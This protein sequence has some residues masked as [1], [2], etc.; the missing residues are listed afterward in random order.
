MWSSAVKLLSLQQRDMSIKI[1]G[2][3]TEIRNHSLLI[4]MSLVKEKVFFHIRNHIFLNLLASVMHKDSV[5][6]YQHRSY[7]DMKKTHF[8]VDFNDLGSWSDSS[9]TTIALS[10]V[11]DRYAGQGLGWLWPDHQDL[12]LCYSKQLT[13]SWHSTL[14]FSCL[15]GWETL[16]SSL[17]FLM[18]LLF[19]WDCNY[20]DIH[21]F[22]E[23]KSYIEELTAFQ[24]LQDQVPHP[25]LHCWMGLSTC[26]L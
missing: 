25:H 20:W 19:S 9:S 4:L 5:Q 21:Q 14:L 24:S 8:N 6:W 15:V 16:K 22:I 26:F 11:L 7:E 17:F 1:I 3:Q 13:M 2:E 12:V 23:Y 18:E 10:D